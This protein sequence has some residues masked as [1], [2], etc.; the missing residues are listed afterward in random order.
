MT[1]IQELD[2]Q[3]DRQGNVSVEVRGVSGRKCE[4]LTA[5]LEQALGGVVTQRVYKDSYHQENVSLDETAWQTS[6][7]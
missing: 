4:D 3:I 2:I 7:A 1:E 5:L 6:E